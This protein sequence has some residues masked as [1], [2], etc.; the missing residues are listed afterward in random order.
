MNIHPTAIVEPG[1][2]LGADVTVGPY[3]IIGPDVTLGDGVKVI[4]HAVIV[5]RTTIGPRT[6]VYPFASLGHQPQDLKYAGE[7]RSCA[8]APIAR[9]A[10]M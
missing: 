4:S 6:T 7:T 9:S 10:S 2:R 3:C 8:S 1:A 5:G